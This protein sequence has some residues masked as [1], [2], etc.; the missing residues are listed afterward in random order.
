MNSTGEIYTPP[1]ADLGAPEP[2]VRYAGFWVRVGAT[3]LDSI[4]EII[5][6]LAL[7]VLI[8]GRDYLNQSAGIRGP[9]DYFLQLF[10]PFILVVGFWLKKSATPG[11]MAFNRVIAHASDF[12]QVTHGRFV[13]R[14]CMY[15]I[16]YLVFGLGIFG[17]LLIATNRAGTTKLLVLW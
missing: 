5:V 6:I 16:S 4:W 9:I 10:L 13:L 15:F 1:S 7:G 3:I 2:T 12:G 8:Y 14:Y 11:K 17:W